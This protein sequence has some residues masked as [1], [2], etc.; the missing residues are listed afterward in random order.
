MVTWSDS[1]I[2]FYVILKVI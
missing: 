2:L 1:Y